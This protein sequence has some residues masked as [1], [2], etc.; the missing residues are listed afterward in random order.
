[1]EL[2]E[3]LINNSFN[4]HDLPFESF[5]PHVSLVLRARRGRG[6]AWNSCEL[7]GRGGWATP[8]FAVSLIHSSQP[9]S[10]SK[11]QLALCYSS[12]RFASYSPILQ[13]GA[14]GRR[15]Q[16]RRAPGQHLPPREPASLSARALPSPAR[17]DTAA[18]Q[19]PSRLRICL[20]IMA[21]R[22]LAVNVFEMA[23]SWPT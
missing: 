11:R 10:V 1:M 15:R 7:W 23:Y 20:G 12:R 8:V 5:E 22:G 3:L 16:V 19:A 13:R 4:F 2:V 14:R 21:A 18:P 6:M 17:V 9:C